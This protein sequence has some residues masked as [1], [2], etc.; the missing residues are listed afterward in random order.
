MAV[1]YGTYTMVMTELGC[2]AASSTS[3]H[4]RGEDEERQGVDRDRTKNQR[5]QHHP[6]RDENP[7]Q[8]A[9]FGSI[10]TFG[11]VLRRTLHH[12]GGLPR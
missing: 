11:V 3:L 5:G 6:G 4:H 2:E 12:D 9:C 8:R 7:A 10:A 1:G